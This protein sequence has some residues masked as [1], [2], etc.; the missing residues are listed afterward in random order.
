VVSLERLE[1]REAPGGCVSFEHRDDRAIGPA[2]LRIFRC[3]EP[4]LI[5]VVSDYR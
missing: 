4:E 2:W 3:F 5:V 1:E